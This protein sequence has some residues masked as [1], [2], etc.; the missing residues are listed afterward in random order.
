LTVLLAAAVFA[1]PV[2]A[3]SGTT[4]VTVTLVSD[5][6]PSGYGQSVTFTA[7][8][9]PTTG[10]GTPTGTV[11]FNI[12]G[13]A[14]SP[15]VS[16][17]GG[18][19][20]Y[21]T[22]AWTT[23]TA[24]A[25]GSHSI[26]ATYS[27]DET[28][29]GGISNA[30][31]QVVVATGTT[32]LT[33]F[34]LT[35]GTNPSIY[36]QASLF[37]ATLVGAAGTPPTGTVTL[38]VNGSPLDSMT[39]LVQVVATGTTTA[40]DI[41]SD[42]PAGT[43]SMTANYSGDST[44]LSGT[45][46]PLIVQTVHK[47]A[48]TT[49]LTS[50]NNPSTYGQSVTF[51]A[52]VYPPSGDL[53]TATGSVEFSD[54]NTT[55]GSADLSSN[56]SATFTTSAL[57]AGTHSITAT[58]SGDS[59]LT[60]G[61][62]ATLSQ[63]VNLIRTPV[64]GTAVYDGATN[65]AWSGTEVSG[66]SAYDTSTVTGVSGFTPTGTVSYSLFTNAAC[67]GASTP[68][69]TG[70]ALG[71]NSSTTSA[72]AAGSYG[73]EATY[74]GDDNYSGL[75][76]SCESF[77]V[78][79][80]TPT[81]GTTVYDGTNTAWSNSELTGA[82]AYDTSTVGGVTGFTATGTVSYTLYSNST[83]CTTTPNGSSATAEGTGLSL[84]TNSSTT[85]P[86]AAGTYYFQASY[87]GDGSYSPAISACESFTVGVA[88][89]S[90]GTT[91]YD[92]TTN[93]AWSGTEV[94]GSSAYDNSTVTGVSGF[95]PTGTVS[96][97][98]FTNA[99]CAGTSTPEGTGL[100]L[101]TNSNSTSP[102]AAGTYGFEAIYS[103]DGNY[104]GLTSSCE[105]FSVREASPTLTTAANLT[106]VT[107]GTA[108]I[109]EDTATLS[110]GYN[111]G[112]S[113]TFTLVGP[114]SATVDTEAVSVSGDGS[115]TTPTGY[116][117]PITNT[118]TVAGTYQW[119]ASYSG[120]PNNKSVSDNGATNEQVVV[121]PA[122][123][124]L[125]YTGANQVGVNSSF[126]ATATLT[127]PAA[128]CYMG[129]PVNLSVSPDPLNT[130]ISSLSLGTPNSSASGA[131]SLVVST[132]SWANGIY[133]I[134][135]SYAGTANCVA[136]TNTAALAV[137]S[138]GQFAFGGGWYKIPGV[139]LTSFDFVVAQ[140]PKSTYTGELNVVTPGSWWFQANV[141]SYGKTSTTQALLAGT[142]SLYSWSR[143]STRDAGAGSSSS[144]A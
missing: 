90:V 42:L 80:A 119:D 5:S 98:L 70:L 91:V 35:S 13:T 92:G 104:S 58:Y 45:S 32:Q 144:R 67:T 17:V 28:Y 126:N 50:D 133:A 9:S 129:Q 4:P 22:G 21:M 100:A 52:S 26:T 134:T 72:L 51:T 101:G 54:G 19:A 20:S 87:S 25:Y 53:P 143:P 37:T 123:T 107:F 89:P 137:T 41:V 93:V 121:S 57:T 77:T 135:A 86:L 71:T 63:V 65:V 141:T 94:S 75:T 110:G 130:T 59:N 88:A 122:T 113:I 124:T 115:Y 6:N 30:L 76:S 39:T 85:S 97:S 81:V 106:S 68:E 108:A 49:A 140:G 103:G 10:T 99:A 11:T 125:S 24:L 128:S 102:L 114:G 14:A 18:W 127:S 73:F 139:G 136:S 61:T 116:A 66:S 60:P 74:S 131:V 95:T 7:E 142:G 69:G 47:A 56:G 118:G 3:G 96:Y 111:P 46:S 33:S 36:G 82:T 78:G 23:G 120:D 2:R 43:D 12:D 29:L 40:T 44:Y 84:G 34:T 132:K 112:G 48:A 8:V 83:G 138:P 79:L 38:Y 62:P 109:L 1:G 31:V 27:G 55:L 16:L 117:L 105:S 64:V 15:S